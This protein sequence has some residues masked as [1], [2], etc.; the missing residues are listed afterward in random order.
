MVSEC[1]HHW[2]IAS[3]SGEPTV[4]GT[5]TR[6]SAERTFPVVLETSIWE[7]FDDGIPEYRR[8]VMGRYATPVEIVNTW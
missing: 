2:R 5:C 3:P 7:R 1:R 4:R 6:C 8:A